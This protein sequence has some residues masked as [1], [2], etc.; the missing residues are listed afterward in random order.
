MYTVDYL[1][2]YLWN[3]FSNNMTKIFSCIFFHTL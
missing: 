1:E 3:L 2:S